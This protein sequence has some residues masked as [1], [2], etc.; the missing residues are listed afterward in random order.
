MKQVAVKRCKD[1]GPRRGREHCSAEAYSFVSSSCG[2]PVLTATFYFRGELKL[3]HN[4]AESVEK[5]YAELEKHT[6]DNKHPAA[7][8]LAVSRDRQ[9]NTQFG[10]KSSADNAR[11][12]S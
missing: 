12:K 11:K 9:E 5:Y 8:L 1:P 6:R 4:A 7:A 2:T 3:S 10:S